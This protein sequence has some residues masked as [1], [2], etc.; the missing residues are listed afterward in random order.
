MYNQDMETNTLEIT[1]RNT[2]LEIEYF[3]RLGKEKTLLYLHG[4][5]CSK[6]DFLQATKQAELDKYSIISFDFPGC[7]NSPYPNNLHLG[8]DDLVDITKEVVSALELKNITLIGHSMGGLVAMLYIE[9]HDGVSAFISVEGN[10]AP[11]NCV[12]SRKVAFGIDFEEFQKRTFVDLQKHLEES[13]N[14]GFQEWAKSLKKSSAQAFY[15]YC[16]S[17]VEYSD[18]G[19]VFEHYLQL[20]IPS[21]YIYGSENKENLT[22]LDHFR[23]VK[24]R[25]LEISASNHFPFFDNPED[26]YKE[27]SLFLAELD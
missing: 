10:L 27:V 20:I 26:F 2:L 22:F 11:E 17:I 18:S 13:E 25:Q 5:A 23:K 7:G 1:Y 16:P 12:F 4:G 14:V 6:N 21:L 9:K 19:K 3:F 24:I 15:D 8:M